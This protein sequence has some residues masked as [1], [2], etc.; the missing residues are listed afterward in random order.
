MELH[1]RLG[2]L[3]RAREISQVE[4]AEALEVSRQAVSKW[5]SGASVP[6]MESFVALSRLY[7]I[8]VDELLEGTAENREEEKTPEEEKARNPAVSASKPETE[9]CHSQK[10][11]WILILA[12]FYSTVY[13]SGILTNARTVSK[14]FLVFCTFL[15]LAG[16]FVY[17]LFKLLWHL[18][19][20]LRS[21]TN[22]KN[23]GK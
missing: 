4:L 1:E 18:I 10:W 9:A 11:V 13:I 14:S 7:G 21:N 22:K 23:G 2:R 20:Y 12:G 17:L 8:P 6:S 3:R 16:G 5:E 19:E 15:L